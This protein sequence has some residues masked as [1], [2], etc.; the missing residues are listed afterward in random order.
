ME[1]VYEGRGNK[2][3]VIEREDIIRWRHRYLRDIRKFRS[4]NRKIYFTDESW[5]NVGQ[6]IKAGW[7]DKTV[8]STRQP[9]DSCVS[10]GLK[11]HTARGPRFALV[12]AGSEDSFIENT[13]LY[14]RKLQQMPITK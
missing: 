12:H 6:T 2:G 13:F 8:T 9:F 7:K 5:V 1:F 10:M 11:P 14:V 4:E 3:T